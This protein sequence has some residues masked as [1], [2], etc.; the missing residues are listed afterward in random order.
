MMMV[1]AGFQEQ[2]LYR[3]AMIH[4]VTDNH[5]Q[6]NIAGPISG[7]NLPPMV[8]RFQETDENQSHEIENQWRGAQYNMT[9]NSRTKIRPRRTQIAASYT[10]IS[11]IFGNF[12]LKSRKFSAPSK[13]YSIEEED[14]QQA[15]ESYITIRPALWLA[16][17]GLKYG[18]QV[19]ISQ[20]LGNW[21]HALNT[22]RPVPDDSLIFDFC[23]LGNIDGVRLL[24]DKGDASTWDTN[25]Q[26]RTPLHVSSCHHKSFPLSNLLVLIS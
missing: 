6:K 20:S 4:L 13:V 22:F 18:I 8:S 16:R 21:K 23:K 5:S 12:I 19:A 25:S 11:S 3:N 10:S 2:E 1:A 24:L 15:R 26:G 17:F 7:V 14:E 9:S